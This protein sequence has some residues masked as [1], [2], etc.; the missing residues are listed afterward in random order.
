MYLNIVHMLLLMAFLLLMLH[1]DNLIL[2]LVAVEILILAVNILLG[3]IGFY[4]DDIFAVMLIL[5]LL[6]I[7]AA[8]SAVGLALMVSFYR[9]RFHISVLLLNTNKG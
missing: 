8:D 5:I 1:K 9:L 2:I 4:L 6:A 7:A 3:F